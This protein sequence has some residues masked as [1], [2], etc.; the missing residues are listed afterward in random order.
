MPHMQQMEWTRGDTLEAQCAYRNA[1]T[2]AALSLAGITV[3][4]QIRDGKDR[5]LATA[6]VSV[7]SAE[8][9]EFTLLF[10]PTDA[11]PL[12]AVYWNIAYFFDGKK[13]STDTVEIT[14]TKGPTQ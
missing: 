13:L 8:N 6:Q 10:D 3:K 4:S 1:S 7:T 12:G 11:F 2:D 9:G 5:L 14:I